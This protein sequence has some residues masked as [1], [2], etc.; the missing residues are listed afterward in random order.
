MFR[1]FLA[2]TILILSIS[3]LSKAQMPQGELPEFRVSGIVKDSVSNKPI[4]YATIALIRMK[5]STIADG[6]ITDAKGMFNM[7]VKTAGRFK[8]RI[9]F[10]GYETKTTAPVMLKPGNSPIIN[11]GEIKLNPSVNML[12]GFEVKAE[13][14]LVELQIDK[15]VINVDQN[16]TATGGTALDVLKDAPSV[17]VDQ[18]GNVSLRGSENVTVLIDGRPSSMTGANRKAALEQIQASSIETV[19]II[20]NPSAKYNP[21][22]MSGI[23]NIVLK[24]KK[25]SG[26]NSLLSLNAGTKNKYSASYSASYSTDKLSVFAS[27][28]YGNRSRKGTG[29]SARET[30]SLIDKYRLRQNSSEENRN[31]SHAIK[32]GFDYRFTDRN[33]IALSVNGML[34]RDKENSNSWAMYEDTASKPTSSFRSLG[35]EKGGMQ[36]IE[37]TFNYKHK[38]KKPLHEITTDIIYS[39]GTGE[40]SSYNKINYFESDMTTPSSEDPYWTLTKG[41]TGNNILTT[42]VDYSLPINDS[43]K[44][45]AGAQNVYRTIDMNTKYFLYDFPTSEYLFD[46]LSSNHFLYDEN[47]TAIYGTYTS[48]IKKIGFSA[49]LRAEM[50]NTNARV[51]DSSDN[52]K[53]YYSI[54]PT[55]AISYKFN[56]SQEIQLTYSKRINRPSFHDLNPYIDYENY[57]NLRSGNP[58]LDPE[59]IHSFEIS[60]AWYGKKGSFIPS[61]YY[62]RVN[63]VIS[64]YRQQLSDTVFLMTV[65]NYNSAESF[66]LEMIFTRSLTKYWKTNLN[67]SIYRSIIDGSN[68]ETSITGE[69]YGWNARMNNSFTLPKGFDLQ[70]SFNYNGPRFTGQGTR[71]AFFASEIGIKKTFFD[72]K[73]T[74]SG[75]VSDLFNSMRFG[76]EF[77]DETYKQTMKRVPEGRIFWIGITWKV[78]GDYKP[79]ERKRN[80]DNGGNGMEDDGF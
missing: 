65:E 68:V 34:F 51:A 72:K 70:W 8:I 3:I 6:T 9:S 46:P 36:N 17:E 29:E 45:E 62:K 44:F 4:E 74:V 61:V 56:K 10:M 71:L 2:T 33:I 27:Y 28:D 11:M 73:L 37:A 63:D 38:F 66:G 79:K 78:T 80:N 69:S 77:E 30:F 12:G 32:A 24:K 60:Y 52:K 21:D 26:F 16:L 64:R 57:P 49:G 55:A 47:I 35:I 19:E 18:D 22:G 1:T 48:K 25:G 54:F 23:I 53:T 7:K 50:A 40:D 42:K 14:Q 76:M 67:G 39:M 20:T 13:K 59:Y 58:Y 15:K 5:D 31:E 41:P 75:R 43:T